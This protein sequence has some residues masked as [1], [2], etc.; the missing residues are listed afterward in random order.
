MAML[1]FRTLMLTL[2]VILAFVLAGCGEQG[3]SSSSNGGTDD[4]ADNGSEEVTDVVDIPT[5]VVDGTTAIERNVASPLVDLGDLVNSDTNTWY[6][7]RA[8]DVNDNGFIV[9]QSNEGTFSRASFMWDPGNRTINYLGMHDDPSFI[10]SEAVSINNR[11]V[12][13]GNSTTGEGW[14]EEGEKRAFLYN[15]WSET[16]NFVDLHP[17][18]DGEENTTEFSESVQIVDVDDDFDYVLIDADSDDGRQAYYAKVTYT[19]TGDLDS[20]TYHRIAR[21]LGQDSEAV[22]INANGHIVINSGDTAIYWNLLDDAGEVLNFFPGESSTSAVDLNDNG[23]VVGVSG[24]EG[25]FWRGG[26]MYP[27]GHLGGGSSEA[28]DVNNND[29]VAGFST[30]SDDSTHAVVWY[31]E[32][33]RGKLMDLGTLGGANSYATAIN[34]AGQVV[35]YS[36]TGE[37][38][39]EGGQTVNVVHGF[40]WQDGIM[41]DLGA[42]NDFYTYPFDESYPMSEAVGISENGDVVGN[43]NSIN[44]HYRGFYIKFAP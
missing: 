43:S 37:T 42:H 10:Y 26:S 3:S 2:F 13:L 11:G 44:N 22:A 34:D 39:T 12:I 41:Y 15:P 40:L 23:H 7:T 6:Y 4:N 28:V 31:L 9:G 32:D 33:G 36:E 24:D 35:G 29:Q 19:S 25:F 16:S 5:D 1:R 38:Y 20:I 18:S 8:F 17:N 14:P 30:R 21:I 27:M